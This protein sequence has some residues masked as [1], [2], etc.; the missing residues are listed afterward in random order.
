MRFHE[1]LDTVERAGRGWTALIPPGWMQG[2][3]IYGGMQVALALRAMR[4]A[5]GPAPPLR[6]LHATFVAPL[7]SGQVRLRTEVLRTGRSVAHVH[8]SLLLDD[9]AIA[10]TVVAIFGAAR[11]SG[12]V[13]EIPRP[14]VTDSP[15]ELEDMPYR[16]GQTP[17][18]LQHMQ[19]RWVGRACPATGQPEPRTIV[20]A[21]LREPG[22]TA[23]EA[24]AGLADIIPT[25]ALST[26][27]KPVPVSSLNWML[28]FVRDP[29]HFDL[30]GWTLIDTNARSGMDGYVSQTSVLWGPCGHA[31]TVSHQ[32]VAIF[33]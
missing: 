16:P 32:T 7:H 5:M 3:A 11:T 30:T 1:V 9:G 10:C 27:R 26:L 28:E 19:L 14:E 13:R 15:E 31:Y 20:Y 22:G 4:G 8:C 18:F 33:G 24:L 6:S 29:Q 23:E 2:R 12:F 17:T 25:P 21:R